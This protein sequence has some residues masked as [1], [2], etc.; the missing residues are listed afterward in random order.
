MEETKVPKPKAAT[1]PASTPAPAAT[2]DAAQTAPAQEEFE[3][4]KSKKTK[5][6]PLKYDFIL[7]EKTTPKELEAYFDAEC[8]M[9]NQDRIINETY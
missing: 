1:T 3:I 9:K 7:V 8:K 2:G 6:T 4:K 5:Q